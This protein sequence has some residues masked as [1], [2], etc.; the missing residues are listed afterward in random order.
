[1]TPLMTTVR[2]AGWTFRNRRA[3]ET[4][5]QSDIKSG[6]ELTPYHQNATFLQELW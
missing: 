4:N 2:P 6:E 3:A 1:L 5:L